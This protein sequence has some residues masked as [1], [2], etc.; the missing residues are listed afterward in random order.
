[1][2]GACNDANPCTLNDT[3]TMGQCR[4]TPVP[5]NVPLGG[6]PLLR[7][8]VSQF[9]GV[10]TATDIT[11]SAEHCGGCGINCGGFVNFFGCVPTQGALTCGAPPSGR[12]TCS[13]PNAMPAPPGSW[14]CN[15]AGVW[16]PQTP[17]SC[18]AGQLIPASGACPALCAP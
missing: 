16:V 7:C 1:V 3:C 11:N 12:C 13:G 14:T 15:A 10:P 6:N 18:G 17:M 5:P 9:V 4:G 8:C 2:A